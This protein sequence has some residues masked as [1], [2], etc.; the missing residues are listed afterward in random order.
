MIFESFIEA[1]SFLLWSAFV[2]AFI[3]GAVVNK[4]NFCT[5]GAVSDM[6]NMGDYGRFRAWLLAICVALLGVVL[7]ES[8]GL[9][10]IDSAFPPYRDT[11]IIWLENILGGLMFGIGMTLGSGCGNKALI[12]IGGGN[13]KS[14]FLF[15]GIG[16]VAFYMVNPF[17]GSDK[18]LYSEL[19]FPWV[20]SAAIEL[21]GLSDLGSLLGGESAVQVRLVIGLLLASLALLYILKSAEFR[22]SL[23]NIL[24]G[25]VV[26]LVVVGAWYISANVAVNADDEI[27]NLSGYYAEWEMLSDTT[28]GKPSV[29]RPLSTQSF[30]FVNPMAQTFGYAASGFQ[31]YHLTFGIFAVAGV[32]LGS[33]FWSLISRSFRIEW[34]ASWADFTN[35]LIAAVLMGMG[36]TIA[37]GCTIGQ[38]VTGIS[39]LA[40]GSFLTFGAILLGSALT[41][42]TQY[43]KMLYE[44]A[45]FADALI[46]AMVE[47]RLL[48]ASMRRL[49]AL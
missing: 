1:H 22:S 37:L 35:H 31:S 39:T 12:R 44:D 32:I 24:G 36:A 23:D 14:I 25:L 21:Q 48:P 18:T 45:S 10:S 7:L 49:E 42:K 8:A 34:F 41:M 11:R 46:T 29:S 19:F 38:A 26:G 17:P 13:I 47:L 9:M 33:L 30:T 5:M 6:V 4:T 20:G 15:V 43:Y 40:V 2:L 16:I 28:E 3:M 27:Y